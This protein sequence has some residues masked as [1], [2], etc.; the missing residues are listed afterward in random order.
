MSDSAKAVKSH[1][2]GCCKN[3]SKRFSPV[4]SAIAWNFKAKF[5]RLI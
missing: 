5:Y 1:N 4:F 2:S 3:I